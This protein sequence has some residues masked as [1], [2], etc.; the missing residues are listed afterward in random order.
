MNIDSSSGRR[1]ARSPSARPRIARCG[2]PAGYSLIEVL[3]ATALLAG[4]VISIL[5]M[6]IY[7]GQHINA[8]R[9]MT[10]GTSIATDVLEE[11]RQL[12]FVQIPLLLE[13]EREDGDTSYEWR[14]DENGPN[15]PAEGGAYDAIL[16]A[17]KATVEASLPEGRIVITAEGIQSLGANPTAEA[18]VDADVIQVVVTVEWRERSRVRSIV[19]E[20]MKI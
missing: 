6:F 14:S 11:I 18:F 16:Q 9:L 19:F 13:D 17:W 15:R 5:T 4:V 1:L 3:A 10:T 20:T 8:G 2:D 12:N 7:G